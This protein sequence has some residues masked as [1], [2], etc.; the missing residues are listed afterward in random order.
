MRGDLDSQLPLPGQAQAS[1]QAGAQTTGY[2]ERRV[3]TW[4]TDLSENVW[5][6]VPVFLQMPLPQ[7]QSSSFSLIKMTSSSF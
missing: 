3:Q 2:L 1:G 7:P 5:V 6:Y 4:S